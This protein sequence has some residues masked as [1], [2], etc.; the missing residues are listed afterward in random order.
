MKPIFIKI[1]IELKALHTWTEFTHI[2][3]KDEDAA[4]ADQKQFDFI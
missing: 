2:Y 4:K 1:A 3:A